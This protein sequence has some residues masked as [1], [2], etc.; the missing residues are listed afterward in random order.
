MINLY[1]K[2]FDPE[3]GSILLPDVYSKVL[4]PD[5]EFELVS[6]ISAKKLVLL[7]EDN[8]VGHKR[9]VY[10][11]DIADKTR[12]PTRT[13]TFDFFK[14]YLGFTDDEIM[15]VNRDEFEKIDGIWHPK[16]SAE[17]T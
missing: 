17:T 5:T 14:T 13:A 8:V 16:F 15:F 4:S 3:K 2:N 7:R 6:C 11:I 10:A 1:L 9:M 12:E